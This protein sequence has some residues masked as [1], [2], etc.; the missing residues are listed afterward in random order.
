[1]LNENDIW[2]LGLVLGF[3]PLIPAY[4]R[5]EGENKKLKEANQDNQS[6]VWG[7][8][9][10]FWNYWSGALISISFILIY[11]FGLIR[12]QYEGEVFWLILFAS[13]SCALGHQAAQ[14]KRWALILL[15]VC[16]WNIVYFAINYFYLKKRWSEL[17][18]LSDE[19]SEYGIGSM[20]FK[21]GLHALTL[22]KKAKLGVLREYYER[23]EFSQRLM[24]ATGFLWVIISF[25]Y[26]LSFDKFD[27][28]SEQIRAIYIMFV[29][30]LIPMALRFIYLREKKRGKK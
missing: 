16:S 23:L 17:E 30:P 12:R 5:A 22:I 1:M 19:K 8:T 13:V 20:A 15:T 14:R 9:F 7:Y 26:F 18:P 6:F 28:D 25:L 2:T 3:L 24:I 21:T 10:S 27:T 29:P 4:I 11:L